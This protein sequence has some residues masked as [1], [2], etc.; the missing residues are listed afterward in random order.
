MMS[1]IS[2][3][4]MPRPPF[5]NTDTVSPGIS[6]RKS[7]AIWSGNA[8]SD[9]LGR[10]SVRGVPLIPSACAVTEPGC[11][12]SMGLNT[13]ADPTVRIL[14]L[15]PGFS[16]SANFGMADTF[17]V[18]SGGA[19]QI[20]AAIACPMDK[21]NK[22]TAMA[23]QRVTLMPFMTCK[24]ISGRHFPRKARTGGAALLAIIS[25]EC[26]DRDKDECAADVDRDLDPPSIDILHERPAEE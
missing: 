10:A 2:L 16:T 3:A 1:S 9:G 22:I 20:S 4:L 17:A 15:P 8:A 7:C 12:D 19:A 23:P 13:V 21:S 11:S 6:S 5:T 26:A 24:S 14:R 25:C 18:I